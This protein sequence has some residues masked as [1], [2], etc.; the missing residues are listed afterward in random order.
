MAMGKSIGWVLA[1][2]TVSLMFVASATSPILSHNAPSG[3]TL[4]GDGSE[5][6]NGSP[7]RTKA[8]GTLNGLPDLANDNCAKERSC[9]A[10]KGQ[11][12]QSVLQG[13]VLD[14]LTGNPVCCARVSLFLIDRASNDLNT[15]I[16]NPDGT[17]QPCKEAEPAAKPMGRCGGCGDDGSERP[18]ADPLPPN[19]P[20]APQP[21]K[22]PPVPELPTPPT[23]MQPAGEPPKPP[24]FTEPLL[25][26]KTDIKGGYA[27]KVKAGTFIMTV[28]AEGYLPFKGEVGVGQATM[29]THDV[30]L[31]PAPPVPAPDCGINGNIL[32][33]G[34]GKGIAGANV[35]IVYLPEGFPGTEQQL[36]EMAGN[37]IGMMQGAAGMETPD[38]AMAPEEK[39]MLAQQLKER[40]AQMKDGA[41]QPIT[42]EQIS[43]LKERLARLK[44]G[45]GEQPSQDEIAALK[46]KLNG[47][48]TEEQRQQILLELEAMKNRMA[49]S[50][51]KGTGAAGEPPVRE[52]VQSGEQTTKP[53]VLPLPQPPMERS[54]HVQMLL[55]I[56]SDIS[57]HYEAKL[58]SGKVLV[59]AFARGYMPGWA[60]VDLPPD[61]VTSL[62]LRLDP[63]P[64]CDPGW[65]LPVTEPLVPPDIDMSGAT[66]G[67]R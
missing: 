31:T 65:D 8:P 6:A 66:T 12:G 10:P 24:I 33:A 27:L 40:L 67:P 5:T 7:D 15:V 49:Q 58:F 30:A 37:Y 14:I 22:T 2:M 56:L 60:L 59:I 17:T 38:A 46:E 1:A 50:Q 18:A 3:R 35:M 25:Q 63:A 11:M 53:Q 13:R 41:D 61:S 29:F 52:P 21:E 42:D 4:A 9:C 45:P 54:A 26:A 51:E 16:R 32:D 20:P 57:G 62:D 28:E 47:Q 44:E 39:E 64:S 43:Q 48:L 36:K 34:T 19:P 23:E 55:S